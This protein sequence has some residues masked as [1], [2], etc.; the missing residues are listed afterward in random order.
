MVLRMSACW[1][2]RVPSRP[3]SKARTRVDR[4]RIEIAVDARV[5]HADLLLHLQ[6]RELRLLQ[7]LGQSRAASEQA[8]RR[9]I[10]IGAELGESRHLAVLRELAL[11]AARDLLHRLGLRRGADARHRE[12]DVHRRPDALIEQIGLEEDLAIRD[13]DDIG[14][15]VGRHVVGLRLDHRQRGQRAALVV[16]V[17]LGGALEQARMQIEH[18]ARIGF[19]A[20][21]AAQQQRHLAI[22]DGLL[23]KIVID[24]HRV[25]AV[26]AEI[27]AHGAAGER[28]QELHRRRI[29]RG[30]RDDDG[31]FERAVFL[32]HLDE[33]RHRRALLSD[34]DID[35]I[36]LDL[37]V[38]R[39]R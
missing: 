26:V 12:A 25:H 30:R 38:A 23:G 37:L 7:K 10:E 3:S 29:G 1:L 14:R 27:F 2:R 19:A 33:L 21:R 20:R 4:K 6:R 39:R 35:A 32:Q 9:G 18:V 16:V 13:G 24:D 5:D 34:R 31:I 8:L 36:E 11:D 15:N 17:H 28:R 22:G